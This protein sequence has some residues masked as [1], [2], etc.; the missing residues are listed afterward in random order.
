M[1]IRSVQNPDLPACSLST[2]VSHF[3]QGF[4]GQSGSDVGALGP[5]GVVAKEEVRMPKQAGSSEGREL[6]PLDT[7]LLK[8]PV[9]GTVAG[10]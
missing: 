4:S 3:P 6:Y 8:T 5:M 9:A 1:V 2:I 7:N 10:S